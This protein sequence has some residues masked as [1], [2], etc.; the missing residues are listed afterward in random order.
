[1]SVKSSSECLPFYG[2]DIT[3]FECAVS[4]GLLARIVETATLVPRNSLTQT[5]HAASTKASKQSAR[6]V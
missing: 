6:F 5:T 3:L 4:Q 2:D 1:M